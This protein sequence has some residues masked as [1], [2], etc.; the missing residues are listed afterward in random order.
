M[1]WPCL[2]ERIRTC[3]H[4]SWSAPGSAQQWPG[5]VAK[6]SS[7]S[8]DGDSSFLLLHCL[9]G[10]KIQI[11]LPWEQRSS[12][13][14]RKSPDFPTDFSPSLSHYF[15]ARG[16]YF[17]LQKKSKLNTD[18]KIEIFFPLILLFF[19]CFFFSISPAYSNRGN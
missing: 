7:S 9:L 12:K 18:T 1:F 2:L 16:V 3:S 11:N 17:N 5:Q 6:P 4:R 10:R 15:P 19:S 8:R 13:S 14:W